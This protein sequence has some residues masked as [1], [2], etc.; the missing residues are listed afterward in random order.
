MQGIS[1]IS[2][3]TIIIAPVIILIPI[4][5]LWYFKTGLIKSTLISIVRMFIQ[6]SLVAIY[7]EFIFKLNSA[8]LNC[9]WVLIMIFVG[10]ITTINRS[11]L[12][13]KY[14]IVPLFIAVTISLV[15]IDSFFL[16]FIIKLDNIFD[17][18]YFVPISGMILGNS[19]N[20]NIVGM[21]AYFDNL[22]KSKN[23]Y[24]FLLINSN[25]KI[26]AL[27]PFIRDAIQKGINPLIAYMS[28]IGL[29]SLPGMMTG[30]ILGGS[31]PAVAIKY[32]IMIMLAIFTGCSINLI[33]SIIFS[34]RFVFDKY[35]RLNISILKNRKLN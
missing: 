8:L 20:H 25:S 6:L 7:L 9:L 32:Q 27:S 35:D 17:A 16:G 4:A 12:K 33:L 13:L 28:V 10:V 26:A 11:G 3:I 23:L 2:L 18:R 5:G 29:I 19:M 34:N 22:V 1:D 30:Q 15:L 31:S 14:F 21:N 24:H